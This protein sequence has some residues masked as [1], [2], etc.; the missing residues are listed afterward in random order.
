MQWLQQSRPCTHEL[1]LEASYTCC[2]RM[3][4]SIYK[5]GKDLVV[6]GEGVERGESVR[7]LLIKV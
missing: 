7:A 3:R 5:W 2:Q 1:Q 4:T 6:G